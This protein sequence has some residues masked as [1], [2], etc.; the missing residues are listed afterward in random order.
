MANAIAGHLGDQRALVNHDGSLRRQIY[1]ITT[2]V[3]FAVT[4]NE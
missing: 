3:F 4:D 2:I 1:A